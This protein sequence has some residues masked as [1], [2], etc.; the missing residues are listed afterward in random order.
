LANDH[1][2]DIKH[3]HYANPIPLLSIILM[4]KG[5]IEVNGNIGGHKCDIYH[6]TEHYAFKCSSKKN[7][8]YD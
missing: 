4:K 7:V 6:K 2:S 3:V 5:V 1:Q 8:K